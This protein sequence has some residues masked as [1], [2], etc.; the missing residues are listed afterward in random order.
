MDFL[1]DIEEIYTYLGNAIKHQKT[2]EFIES[3]YDM[4]FFNQFR[5]QMTLC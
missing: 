1:A 3:G 2:I 4:T 5:Q